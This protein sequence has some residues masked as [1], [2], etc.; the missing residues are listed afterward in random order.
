MYSDISERVDHKGPTISFVK[1][2]MGVTC[3][4]YTGVS[5]GEDYSLNS[6]GFK[7][8]ATAWLMQLDTLTKYPV[9][10]KDEAIYHGFGRITF[11]CHLGVG[12]RGEPMN[13]E[14]NSYCCV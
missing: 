14:N 7:K 1:S 12:N 9:H 5:W 8:D 13:G 2:S 3:C 10:K 11:G 6:K 4:G